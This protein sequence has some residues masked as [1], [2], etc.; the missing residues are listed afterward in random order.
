MSF[1]A[2][3]IVVAGKTY[4]AL[5]DADGVEHGRCGGARAE[6]A[7]YALVG[8]KWHCVGRV[9]GPEVAANQEAVPVREFAEAGRITLKK[10]TSAAAFDA[11]CDELRAAGHQRVGLL[12]PGRFQFPS[13][14]ADRSQWALIADAEVYFG[15]EVVVGYRVMEHSPWLV[16]LR[17]S[18][19]S[20]NARGRVGHEIVDDVLPVT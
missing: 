16:G 13:V 3:K 12:P 15:C 11:L 6:R 19:V 7:N 18:K 5:V 10:G 14:Y 17:Q 9:S 4:V 2:R 8:R 1:T 20:P